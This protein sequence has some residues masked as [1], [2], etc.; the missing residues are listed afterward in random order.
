MEYLK[1]TV[2]DAGEIQFPAS[3]QEH[4]DIAHG[5]VPPQQ[6]GSRSRRRA[7][8]EPP[9]P[10]QSPWSPSG[11]LGF[12]ERERLD[13]L[14]VQDEEGKAKPKPVGLRALDLHA[15]HQRAREQLD[16]QTST[17]RSSPG[18]AER[19]YSAPHFGE[20]QAN[21]E[22]SALPRT[23]IAAVVQHGDTD[24]VLPPP[25]LVAASRGHI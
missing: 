25:G 20:S 22:A 10:P 5:P 21:A 4:S 15:V 24:L 3:V 9:S 12:V 19:R 18:T 16:R 14:N 8:L 23:P 1:P 6:W 2:V 13:I 7:Q 11:P 17:R